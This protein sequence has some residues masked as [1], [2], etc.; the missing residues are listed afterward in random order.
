MFN[1]KCIVFIKICVVYFNV[2]RSKFKNK[3]KYTVKAIAMV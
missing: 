2:L 1:F 3:K